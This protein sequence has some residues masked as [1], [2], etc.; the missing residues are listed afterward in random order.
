VLNFGLPAPIDVQVVARD[1]RTAVPFALRVQRELEAI[2]GVRDVRLGQV[3]DHPA[4][5]IDVDRERAI[6]LGLTERD[7]A[8]SLLTSLS[9]SSLV[10]PSFWVD[11]KNN[12]NYFVAVQTPYYHV[13][14]VPSLM[15]TPVTAGSASGALASAPPGLGAYAPPPPAVPP[16]VTPIAPYLGGIATVRPIVTR[17]SIHHDTVQ[18]VLDVECGVL[19][20]DL[21]AVAGDIDDAIRRIGKLPAGVSIAVAGQPQTMNTAF[22]RL[23]LGMLVAITL[24]YLLLVVLFQSW[25]DPLL[26]LLAVPA[27]LSGVLWMLAF[28]GTTLNVES[29]MGAIMAIGI[30]ASNSI[31][32]VHFANDRRREDESVDPAEAA[33]YAG[34]TRFRPVLMTALA[35]LLGMLPLALGLGEGGQQNA[36]L[37]RAVIG[38]LIVSTFATL[39]VIPCAYAVLRR[40][41]P[42]MGAHDRAVA[43]AVAE[44]AAH[45]AERPR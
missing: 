34:R 27:S 16:P 31:L 29:L 23:A 8:S 40:K 15:A 21:G 20:R 6:Q 11:P 9:S 13:N 26:I 4:L 10:S 18:P 3:L 38:G 14:D 12:V 7:V 36:P 17:T 32:V 33:L 37:G 22:G 42:T 39:L 30:A 19:G 43:E 25:L 1:Y 24:V 45:H 28:T 35:M 41:P 2:P 5:Q 44:G